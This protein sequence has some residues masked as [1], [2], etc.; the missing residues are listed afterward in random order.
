MRLSRTVCYAQGLVEN[1]LHLVEQ[2][3]FAP[4][5]ARTYYL[6]RSQPPLLSAMVAQVNGESTALV[7]S[8]SVARCCWFM[9]VHQQNRASR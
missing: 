1:L 9:E 5:G 6:N 3:G 7:M 2:H 8:Q 4:N